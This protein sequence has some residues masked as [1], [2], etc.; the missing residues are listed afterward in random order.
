MQ[1]GAITYDGL[2]LSSGG[3][4]HLRTRDIRSAARALKWFVRN[5]STDFVPSGLQVE[6]RRDAAAMDGRSNGLIERYDARYGRASVYLMGRRRAHRWDVEPSS[7]EGLVTDIAGICRCPKDPLPPVTILASWAL[8]LVDPTTGSSLPHQDVHDYG[9]FDTAD[10]RLLGRSSLFARIS[11]RTT[12]N[13]WLS[14]PFD[15]PNEVAEKIARH[16]QSHFPCRFSSKH[17]K[18]WRLNRKGTYTGRRIGSLC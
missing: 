6:V 17:W 15:Q 12:A 5:V 10:G 13:L 16:I 4:H 8:V 9:D 2:P 18:C 11:N 7:L 14:L 1:P 3:A